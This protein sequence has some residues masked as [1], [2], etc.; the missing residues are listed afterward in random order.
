MPLKTMDFNLLHRSYTTLDKPAKRTQVNTSDPF[1]RS[2]SS[3]P[4]IGHLEP[5]VNEDNLKLSESLMIRPLSVAGSTT[6]VHS[7]RSRS[8][9]SA[10]ERSNLYLPNSSTSNIDKSGANR[11]E[12]PVAKATIPKKGL[13]KLTALQSE[14]DDPDYFEKLRQEQREKRKQKTKPVPLS[15][16][17]LIDKQKALFKSP[18]P[19]KRWADVDESETASTRTD[20][21]D[22]LPDEYTVG[23]LHRKILQ[24]SD[25]SGAERSPYQSFSLA[26]QTKPTGKPDTTLTEQAR[27]KTV[28]IQSF[29]VYLEFGGATP[30]PPPTHRSVSPRA[31]P[32]LSSIRNVRF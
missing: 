20:W 6:S 24:F 32:P 11:S 18:G 19:D 8:A 17:K 5:K 13:I 10:Y 29:P 31:L 16:K 1:V 30:T 7:T 3:S 25:Y 23:D 21:D 27:K 12:M 14:K 2:K 22:I 9:G 4:Y 28:P 15:H 26:P